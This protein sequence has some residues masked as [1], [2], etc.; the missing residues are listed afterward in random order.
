MLE[1][2]ALVPGQQHGFRALRHSGVSPGGFIS[3]ASLTEHS[4]FAIK[5]IHLQA[6]P[7]GKPR[8]E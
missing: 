7:V 1:Q 3:L 5:F 4:A 6:E 8:K 2:A